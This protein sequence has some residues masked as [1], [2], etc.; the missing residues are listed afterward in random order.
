ML[1][2]GLLPGCATVQ[3]GVTNPIPG[4]TT[5]AVA[6]FF[7][8]SQEPE[9]V[10][11]G[12]R[13]ALAYFA[14]LQK[15]PGYQVIPVGVVEDTI[16][17]HNLQLSNPDDAL[18]LCELL[19]CDAVVVGA[20][21]DFDPYYPP[22]MGL[23]VSWYSPYEWAFEPGLPIDPQ[24]RNRLWQADIDARR[25]ARRQQALRSQRALEEAHDRSCL[26]RGDVGDGVRARGSNEKDCEPCPP[27]ERPCPPQ[28]SPPQ[29]NA[30]QVK[31][32]GPQI[33]GQSPDVVHVSANAPADLSGPSS[34]PDATAG[35]WWQAELRSFGEWNT[36][37]ENAPTDSA[38]PRLNRPAM[39]FPMKPRTNSPYLR[40]F[41]PAKP[42][43]GGDPF[44]EAE[45]HATE[46]KPAYGPPK[47]ASKFES[48]K[49]AGKVSDGKTTATQPAS[50]KPPSGVQRVSNE[51]PAPAPAAA[52]KRPAPTRTAQAGPPAGPSVPA[53]PPEIPMAVVEFDPRQPLMSY[54]R[55]FDGADSAFV[56]TLRDWL[57]LN[58]NRRAGGWEASL[59]RTQEFIQCCSHLM[60]VEMLTLHG[61]EAQK[62]LVI[63]HRNYR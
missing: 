60:I 1:A 27:G 21:T 58:A 49:P 36:G 33:R 17:Q 41:I 2:I 32:D 16:K 7:N 24:A 23:Q 42:K 53:L 30:P 28:L 59:H 52:A 14:E 4:L 37:D 63:K 10:A 50:E 15:I 43:S 45:L 34:P 5:V 31:A 22:R 6:P 39:P 56:A 26:H 40:T 8:L 55:M 38:A 25:E 13:V 20:I 29:L 9:F 47:V 18:R 54:T 61:G 51:T 62:R 19:G 11:D 57:E 12:R 48:N 3:V 35:P 44:L 46:T